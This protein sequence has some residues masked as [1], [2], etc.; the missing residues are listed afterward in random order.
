MKREE[1]GTEEKGYVLRPPS[2]GT[3]SP[4]ALRPPRPHRGWGGVRGEENSPQSGPCWRER[5]VSSPGLFQGACSLSLSSS[6]ASEGGTKTAFIIAMAT[7]T[8]RCKCDNNKLS[9]HILNAC[10]VPGWM[11]PNLILTSPQ[12]VVQ[13]WI[14]NS[15][16]SANNDDHQSVWL[17]WD[18]IPRIHQMPYMR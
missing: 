8:V 11:L 17:L 5:Q 15:G 13:L 1:K 7:I 16:H 18:Y 12:Q 6:S 10:S 4:P 14:F 3:G 2:L 9:Y